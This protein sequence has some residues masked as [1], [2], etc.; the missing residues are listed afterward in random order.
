M[1]WTVANRPI[2]AT[3]AHLLKSIMF[4]SVA[5]HIVFINI[6]FDIFDA[7]LSQQTETNDHCSS[8]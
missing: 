3:P 4:A 6:S 5:M 1:L 8:P 2:K 7:N